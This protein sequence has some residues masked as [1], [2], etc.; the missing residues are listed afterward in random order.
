MP[1]ISFYAGDYNLGVIL[2]PA[3]GGLIV[4]PII[5][6]FAREAKG[7]GVPEVI[8]AVHRK[9]G[10][11]RPAVAFV[12]ILVSSVTIGSGGSAGREGPIAQIGA[13]FGSMLGRI[14]FRTKKYVRLM[15]SCGVAA[16]VS[17]TFNA[18][19]GGAIFAME[20]L[21][22]GGGGL[23]SA[24][25]I[26]LSAVIGD[27][28][29][30]GLTGF[31]TA[32]LSP[33]YIF[34]NIGEVPI[35]IVVGVV[36]GILSQIWSKIFYKIEYFF[37]DLRFPEPFKPVLGGI[38]VGTMG[39]FLFNYGIMGVGYEDIVAAITGR[40]GLQILLMLGIM[41]IFST[42]FT[43]GSGGS[44]GIFAPSLYIGAMFGAAT[45]LIAQ[46]FFPA[47]VSQPYA[48]A[49]I[50][51]GALFAGACRAPVTAL[52]MIP[53]M[54]GNHQLIIPMI[55]VSTLSYFVSSIFSKS[56][57][58]LVKLEKRG[59]NIKD[60][61]NVLEDIQ[62]KEV[63]S[64]DLEY[65]HPDTK[66]SDI[67]ELMMKKRHPGFPVVYHSKKFL[68]FITIYRLK[69]IRKKE[70]ENMLVKEIAYRDYPFVSP[71][72][73]VY[74]ALNVMVKH[75]YGRIPVLVKKN[76]SFYIEGIISKTDV[77]NA[78]EKIMV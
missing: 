75:N 40:L 45:G 46:Y 4:G 47:V 19:L 65:V 68:G 15:V 27:V 53:E 43:V 28:V 1:R 62:V 54:T 38:L 17:A 18:P 42:S 22:V 9:G 51:M 37:D 77:I 78:Y 48:F 32:F 12:K 39:M 10:V 50:G 23:T 56:S 64:K 74:H 44:G 71:D 66:V 49:L 31:E 58:Y 60:R 7:H 72:D 24:I 57:M 59:V 13:V 61:E 73:T 16:G 69:G 5:Y 55:I 14:F 34:S 20:V 29:T 33:N 8:E 52:I 67:M 36:F 63:M 6:K 3:L 2:L 70:R 26:L 35:F 21:A 25:P 30:G 76:R 11:I 41:K